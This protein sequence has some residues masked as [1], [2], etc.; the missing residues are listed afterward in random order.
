MSRRS[1][2]VAETAFAE[3]LLTM[4]ILIVQTGF[5]GDI[6]L[7]TPVIARVRARYPDASIDFLTHPAGA[8]LVRFNSDIHELIEFDKRG[9]DSGFGGLLRTAGKLRKKR[10]DMVFSL[11][12]SY[13]TAMLLRLSGIPKRFGFVEASFSFLYTRSVRRSDLN[14]EVLRNLAILRTIGEEPREENG[15]LRV[16]L[17]ESVL[18][19]VEG[20]LKKGPAKLIGIAP[21]SVWATKRWTVEGFAKV[22]RVFAEK[23]FQVVLF[24]GPSD[25]EVAARVEQEAGVALSN[26]TGQ[27][28]LIESAAAISQLDLLI[29]NDSAPL[30]LGSAF[31]IPVV[32]LFCA[33][34]PEFG[35]G[36]W[37][38]RSLTLGVEGLSC[39]PC[40]RHGGQTCPTGTHACQRKLAAETVVTASEQLLAG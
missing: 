20:L 39:R 37:A 33:T 30:H 36:P 27:L 38:T 14:H 25:V 15:Q 40:G 21:G 3:R 2:L 1:R 5:L 10:Y 29:S 18:A 9:S 12:K 32:A 23:G 19:R 31:K 7:S 4:K 11:H 8:D 6:I 35:F 13:R 26:L 17:P 28:S 16:Q 34:V 22:A 24:G